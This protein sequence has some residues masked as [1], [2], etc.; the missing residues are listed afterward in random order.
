MA[1]PALGIWA[2]VE[3]AVGGGAGGGVPG[4]W[5]SRVYSPG[6]TPS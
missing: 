6:P 4:G 2:Q 5:C 1:W 3:E